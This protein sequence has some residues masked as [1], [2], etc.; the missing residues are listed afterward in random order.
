MLLAEEPV[1]KGSFCS[2]KV[3]RGVHS[4]TRTYDPACVHRET[5]Q[6]RRYQHQLLVLGR[7]GREMQNVTVEPILITMVIYYYLEVL[8][9]G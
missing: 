7:S 6:S 8:H 1:R 2:E 3:T 5:S 4:F 9:L